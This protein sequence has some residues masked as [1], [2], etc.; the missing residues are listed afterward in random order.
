MKNRQHIRLV[1]TL[2][3]L[4][5]LAFSSYYVSATLFTH[6]H[7]LNGVTIVHSHIHGDVHHTTAPDGGH[8]AHQVTLI[9]LLQSGLL[10]T[11]IEMGATPAQV[12]APLLGKVACPSAIHLHNRAIAHLSLRAPP[13]LVG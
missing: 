11:G 2:A 13:V 3:A 4:M 5:L 8:S 6:S 1:R 7:I 9:A 10:C 12:C